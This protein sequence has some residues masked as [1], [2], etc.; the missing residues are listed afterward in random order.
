MEKGFN[1]MEM[2]RVSG[3]GRSTIIQYRELVELYHP[4][5][6]DGSKN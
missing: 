3:M 5:L 1:L 2:V 4:E 6:R